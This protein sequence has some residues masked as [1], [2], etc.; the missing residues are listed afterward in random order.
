LRLAAALVLALSAA[1]SVYFSMQNGVAAGFLDPIARTE[2]QDEALYAHSSARMARYGEWLTP[3]FLGRYGL[4]KPPLLMWLSGASLKTLG[5]S[6]VWL[7]LPVIVATALAAA[8]LFWW[9]AQWRNLTA[10]LC[11][12][13]LLVSHSLWSTISRL[14]LTDGLLAAALV[15]AMYCLHRDPALERRA[16][17]LAFSAAVAA[18]ILTKS[19]AGAGPLLIAAAFWIFRPRPRLRRLAALAALVAVSA[20]WWF[21]YQLA[22]H[23]RWFWAEHIGVEILAFGAGAPPQTTTETQWQF[24]MRRLWL[25]PVLVVLL[26]LAAPRWLAALRREHSARLLLAWVI[27]SGGLPLVWGYRNNTYLV[28]LAPAM[29]LAAAVYFPWARLQP[30]MLAAAAVTAGVSLAAAP[31]G[32]TVESG[33]DLSRYCASNRGAELIIAE[34]ADEFFSA[35]LPLPKVRYV[36]LADA[37]R[38]PRRS[39][40]FRHLGILANTAEFLEADRWTPIFQA[41]LRQMGLDSNEPIATTI[42]AS[43]ADELR[44]IIRERSGSDFFVPVSWAALAPFPAHETRQASSGRFFLLA[45]RPAHIAATEPV[46]ACYW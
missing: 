3:R 6:R 25:D 16:S 10:G 35:L 43:T 45:R 7:R 18:G 13:L 28:T 11:A 5:I 15:A 22:T 9:A 24:Y 46:G 12:A 19:V 37:S 26:A 29:C 34:P 2:P 21:V 20:G 36:Y 33:D 44:Q 14:A 38:V 40:D 31:R 32:Q 30:L 8:L 17:L 39:L 23:P 42:F 27:V 41:R 4:Y 1:V